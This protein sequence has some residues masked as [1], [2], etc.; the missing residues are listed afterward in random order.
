MPNEA[1]EVGPPRPAS[2]PPS[3]KALAALPEASFAS[4]SSYNNNNHHHNP[5][6]TSIMVSK[7]IL[8][9]F[10]ACAFLAA[11]AHAA[12]AEDDST[13][14]LR[15]PRAANRRQQVVMRGMVGYRRRNGYPQTFA[16]GYAGA[17]TQDAPTY[18]APEDEEPQDEQPEAVEAEE[19]PVNDA[20]EEPLPAPAPVAPKKPTRA[21]KAKR[22]AKRPTTTAAPVEEEEDDE[23]SEE[24]PL[25]KPG[26]KNNGGATAIATAVSRGAGAS[27][28][29]NAVAYGGSF[30]GGT[31]RHRYP[32][33]AQ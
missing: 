4:T 10:A 19:E 17:R 1:A 27:A 25:P 9:A 11:L 24:E 13:V 20:E 6:A 18:A 15:V 8:F 30:S 28:L 7:T 21:Q 31:F 33:S 5:K 2:A 26:K 3:I 14:Y 29:S 23:V 22:P 16:H 32:K 12:P